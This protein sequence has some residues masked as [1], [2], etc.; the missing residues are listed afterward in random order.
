MLKTNTNDSRDAGLRKWHVG[1][2]LKQP[3]PVF[4]WLSLTHITNT[5]RNSWETIQPKLFRKERF[6]TD[7]RLPR[8]LNVSLAPRCTVTPL[9]QLLELKR[10][11]GH[12]VLGKQVFY[13][14]FWGGQNIP[15]GL[16][17]AEN[18]SLRQ[19]LPFQ[20]YRMLHAARQACILDV[21][22]LFYKHVQLHLLPF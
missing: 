12:V 2:D 19:K 8:R 16:A 5:T 15:F 3:R 21:F 17:A 10:L 7:G 4:F 14:H 6:V 11:R 1:S 9:A 18:G 13:S 22:I 20:N